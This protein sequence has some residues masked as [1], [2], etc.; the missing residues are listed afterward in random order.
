MLRPGGRLVV[1]DFFR[2][3][4]LFSRFLQSSY[5]RIVLPV[6][7][8]IITGYGPAYRYLASSIDAFESRPEFI[9]LL[10]EH[11]FQS[12]GRDMFPPVAS[13]IWGDKACD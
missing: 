8:G 2:P 6:V 9:T 12:N 3:E 13:M 10:T 11:G 5:N 7:G 1:L 4:S